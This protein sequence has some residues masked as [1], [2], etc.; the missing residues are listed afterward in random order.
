MEKQLD[1]PY[2]EGGS[3]DA[4]QKVL[5]FATA[6][7]GNQRR[8]YRD[9]PYIKHPVRVMETCRSANASQEILA[10]ALLHDVLEDTE[11]DEGRMKDFLES[12]FPEP[13]ALKVLQLVVELTDIYTKENY[14]HLNRRARKA[15]ELDRI[16][17]TS[18]DAQTI[19]YADI[20]DNAPD[21]T[22][23]DPGFAVKMLHEYRAML[24]EITRGDHN[25]YIRAASTVQNC[26]KML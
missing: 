12:I 14:P 1:I 11:V 21:T 15:K 18:A 16:K 20:I 17:H 10:A 7:H 25:L 5:Q 22:S 26:L 13:V 4:L 2:A 19:K 9:E 3:A 24:K 8:K 23:S 6:A